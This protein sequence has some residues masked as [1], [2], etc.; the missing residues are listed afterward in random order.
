MSEEPNT[1]RDEIWEHMKQMDKAL[2]PPPP[3]NPDGTFNNE[4]MLDYLAAGLASQP[5]LLKEM[6]EEAKKMGYEPSSS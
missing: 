5:K 1:E 2:G 6:V 3:K 4:K